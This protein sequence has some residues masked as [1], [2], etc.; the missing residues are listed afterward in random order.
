MQE[1]RQLMRRRMGIGGIASLAFKLAVWCKARVI[2]KK[3][4]QKQEMQ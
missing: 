3:R 4:I 2:K 1:Q